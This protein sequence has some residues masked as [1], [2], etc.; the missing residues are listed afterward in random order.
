MPHEALH[1]YRGTVRPWDW[2]TNGYFWFKCCGCIHA[3]IVCPLVGAC[4]PD[5]EHAIACAYSLVRWCE[6]QGP[7]M[8]TSLWHVYRTHLFGSG[9]HSIK[10]GYVRVPRKQREAGRH[11]LLFVGFQQCVRSSLAH[12]VC[13]QVKLVCFIRNP[14]ASVMLTTYLPIVFLYSCFYYLLCVRI[15]AKLS[16]SYNRRNL[17]ILQKV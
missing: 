5:T 9:G 7:V 12:L 16:K 13:L 17:P 14:E 10:N 2:L 1:C 11:S 8:T 6:T 4:P 3:V 15:P